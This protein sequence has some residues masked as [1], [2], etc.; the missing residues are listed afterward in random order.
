[1]NNRKTGSELTVSAPFPA[2][3]GRQCLSRTDGARKAAV[4]DRHELLGLG[5]GGL[6]LGG[7]GP[8]GVPEVDDG[9]GLVEREEPGH[10]PVAE[11]D[12]VGLE[13]G[14]RV[15]QCLEVAPFHRVDFARELRRER[16][17]L[18]PAADLSP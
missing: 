6:M 7:R 3:A 8:R 5:A 17:L 11:R 16:P 13:V 10:G 14:K 15:H 18:D 12:L 1:M 9:A 2:R 4:E